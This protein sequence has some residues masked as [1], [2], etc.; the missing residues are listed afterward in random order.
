MS[1]WEDQ[2]RAWALPPSD[3]EEQRCENTIK[4]V[5]EAIAASPSLQKRDVRAFVQGSYR[6][7]TN[8][9]RDSDVDVGVVCHDSLFSDLP[10]M[11]VDADVGL[12]PADYKYETFKDDLGR[13]LSEYF[14]RDTVTR[15]NKAF[16][17]KASRSHVEADVAPFFEHRRYDETRQHLSG[18]ELRP[19]DGIP[20]RVIN[21][22]EQHHRNGVSKNNNTGYRYKSV[23]RIF[24]SL[25]NEMLD[26]E[27]SVSRPII[28]FLNECLVWNVPNTLFGNTNYVEDVRGCL[29]HLINGT[30]A[31]DNLCSGWGEVSELK[32]LFHAGQKWTRQNAHEFLVAA[33][34]FTEMR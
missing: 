6:N 27:M 33:W 24:K 12:L 16:D 8:V 34:H 2:F 18:V 15:G 11:T 13:A 22:P 21:W 19:D 1:G 29:L 20:Q 23:V 10:P 32:Y 9:R 25:R 17:V 28:G 26:Q 4:K 7:N 14:G 31:D 5:R 3:A 30:S